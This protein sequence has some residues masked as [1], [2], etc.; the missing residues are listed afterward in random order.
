[1]TSAAVPGSGSYERPRQKALTAPLLSWTKR[2]PHFR[3]LYVTTPRRCTCI[4]RGVRDGTARSAAL[5]TVASGT[6]VGVQAASAAHTAIGSIR[7]SVRTIG[8]PAT[9]GARHV[10]RQRAKTHDGL[11]GWGW[12]P[13]AGSTL[14]RGARGVHTRHREHPVL[15]T[16]AP[17][18]HRPRAL[19]VRGREFQWLFSTRRRGALAAIRCHAEPSNSHVSPNT[20]SP[21]CP[22]N[23]TVRPRDES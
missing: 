19:V 22:P 11:R 1:V 2:C 8:S 14:V 4:F 7:V 6:D 17:P 12:G 9:C 13:C 10:P 16:R 5:F 15:L 21:S 20:S 23:S 3:S 18:S